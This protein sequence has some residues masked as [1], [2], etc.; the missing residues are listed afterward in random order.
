MARVMHDERKTAGFFIAGTDTGVGKTVAAC[1][2]A[3][4]LKRRGVD[5]G[6]M[7]PIETGVPAAVGVRS[8]LR[9]AS[10]AK[11]GCA[12]TQTDAHVAQNFVLQSGPTQEN[13]GQASLAYDADLLRSAAQVDDARELICP[14]AFAL[15]AAPNVAAKFE[16][17]SVDLA[18]VLDAFRILRERHAL[19][20]VEAA[21]GLLAPVTDESNMADLARAMHLPV[22]LV[23]RAALGTINHT[24]LCLEAAANRG[25]PVVGVILSHTRETLAHG[26]AENLEFLRMKL[27]ERLW[28]ELPFRLRPAM[29]AEESEKRRA[30]RFLEFDGAFCWER[31]LAALAEPVR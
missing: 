10:A 14:L 8:V 19:V 16:N 29:A 9:E 27:A 4:G 11:R 20:L 6:V 21:G 22:V 12:Q 3:A 13:V 1:A 30:E 2:L 5:I 17:R 25:L 23:A 28:G 24:R 26:E 15:P 18:R 7:K 31:I